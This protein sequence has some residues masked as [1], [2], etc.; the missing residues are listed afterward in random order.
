MRRHSIV[1]CWP[2]SC[3]QRSTRLFWFPIAILSLGA[4]VGCKTEKWVDVREIPLNPLSGVLQLT[5]D[6]GPQPTPRTRQFL[7][8]YDLV[9]DIENKPR[10]LL[11]K[12]HELLVEEPDNEKVYS[13]VELAYIHG[14]RAENEGNLAEATDHYGAAVAYAY[15]YLFD[16]R[17][18]AGRNPY[19]PQFRRICDLYNAALEDGLRII[20]Q[21]GCI[22]P[23][24]EV[25]VNTC[26]QEFQIEV[27]AHGPWQREDFGDIKFASDFQSEKLRNQYRT[28][29]LGVPLI[30]TKKRKDDDPAEEYYPDSLCFPATAFLQVTTTPGTDTEG[31]KPTVRCV[32][33]LIDPLDQPYAMVGQEPVPLQTDLTTPLAYFLSRPEFDS[34]TIAKWGLLSPGD[35]QEIRGLYMLE[36]YNPRKVPVIMVHGLMSSPV[37]WIEM[38]NDLRALP[39]LRDNY[40]FWFYLYPTGQPFWVS[41]AQLRDDLA[42][43]REKLDPQHQAL[44]LDQMVLVGHSMGGLVSRLQTIDSEDDYWNL[45]SHES[46]DALEASDEDREQLFRLVFFKANESVRRVVTIGTPHRGSDYANDTA[47]WLARK[48]IS[49][50]N[51][52]LDT[53]RRIV[54]NNPGYF[55]DTWAMT[56]NTSIDSLSPDSPILPLMLE[57]DQPSWI[58][59]HNIVGRIPDQTSWWEQLTTQRLAPDGDGVVAFSSAHLEDVES[60]LVVPADHTSVHRHP[61]SVLAQVPQ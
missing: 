59:Y 45:V 23:G 42:Q 10:V 55:H 4:F 13:F 29:G 12:V 47:R 54:A 49:L 19:D 40:Q 33:E 1:R 41:A 34:N 43:T 14:R 8:R 17:F 39:E 52:M 46:P 5:S 21:N 18:E 57:A 16:T 6:S 61:R 44:A 35:T 20:C 53:K 36:P 30:V 2:R 24:D 60:E 11:D 58:K 28:Y 31:G 48:L 7:R 9:G 51:Y 37:T 56:V 27:V 38:F 22:K 15:S 25:N 50:P 32:L 26:G 3:A